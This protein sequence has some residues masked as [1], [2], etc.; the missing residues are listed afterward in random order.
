VNR[1]R[2]AGLAEFGERGFHAVR[3]DDVVRRAGTSHGTFYLYFASKEDL[4]RTL[5]H[6]ALHDVRLV[7]E[8]FPV[9]T[10][11]AAGRAA[12]H[13]WVKR[14]SV[15]YAAHATVIRILS[16]AE[17]VGEETWAD[18]LQLLYRLADAIT[19]GMTAA[20]VPS[21]A[22]GGGRLSQRY[23]LTALACLMMLERVNYLLSSGVE[24]PRAEMADRLSAI[25]Y[26]AFQAL[27]RPNQSGGGGKANP[28]GA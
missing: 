7:A 20:A 22:A 17:I 26:A 27:V 5:L 13:A 21:P 9:V 28:A 15:A 24:L 3:V 23:E 11:N 2:Q 12:L 4:F 8:D 18:G 6:D 1:L 16:Q 25:I 14:F 10:P 19:Q